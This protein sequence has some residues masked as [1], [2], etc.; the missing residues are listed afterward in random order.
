MDKKLRQ[1]EAREKALALGKKRFVIYRGVLGFGLPLGIGLTAVHCF[2]GHATTWRDVIGL[3]VVNLTGGMVG[4]LVGGIVFGL[5]MWAV[6]KKRQ[7]R[8]NGKE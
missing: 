4:G 1:K 2:Q 5:L 3:I 8:E 6:L 7:R